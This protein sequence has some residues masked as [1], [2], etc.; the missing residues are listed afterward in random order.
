MLEEK[1]IQTELGTF[2]ISLRAPKEN[3]LVVFLSGAG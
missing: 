2:K 3:P 1:M